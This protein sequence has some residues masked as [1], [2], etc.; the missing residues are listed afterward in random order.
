MRIAGIDYSLSSPAIVTIDTE[1][2]AV[3]RGYFLT[4]V[5]RNAKTFDMGWLAVTGT[6]HQ[7]H[8]CEEQRYDQISDW[9]IEIVKDCDRIVLED[10]A[11]GAK[12]RVFHIGENAGLLKYK[13]WRSRLNF[14][15]VGPTALKKFAVGKGNADK[16]MMHEAFEKKTGTNL[17]MEMTPGST[18]F[19]NPVSDIVDACWLAWYAQSL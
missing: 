2:P 4:D 14:S 16:Q 1:T 11:L 19:G 13:M 9:A 5:R 18:K 17:V 8:L 7:H 3:T 6:M 10:Y 12:G 15:L